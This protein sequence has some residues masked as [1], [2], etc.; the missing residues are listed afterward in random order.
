[1]QKLIQIDHITKDH[2]NDRGV[3]DVTLEIGTGE[4]FGFLGPNGA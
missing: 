3:F 2:G 1:M 4:V